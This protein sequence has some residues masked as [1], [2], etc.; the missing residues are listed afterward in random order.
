MAAGPA[1][2]AKEIRKQ[3][4]RPSEV[5]S[6]QLLP[7]SFFFHVRGFYYRGASKVGTGEGKKCE[8]ESLDNNFNTAPSVQ[9]TSSLS[10]ASHTGTNEQHC[11]VEARLRDHVPRVQDRELSSRSHWRRSTSKAIPESKN[12]SKQV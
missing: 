12:L 9:G 2:K 6:H 11:P 7:V 5:R 3:E 4:P 1:K 10:P 8:R